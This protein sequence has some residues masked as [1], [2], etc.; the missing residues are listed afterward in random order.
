[1]GCCASTPTTTTLAYEGTTKK[2][3]NC[4]SLPLLRVRAAELFPDL[5]DMVFEMVDKDGVNWNST[6]YTRTLQQNHELTVTIRRLTPF[7]FE[8]PQWERLASA[9][10][11]LMTKNRVCI[12]VGF[13]VSPTHGVTS[14]EALKREERTGLTAHFDKLEP[15]EVEVNPV[16]L[17]KINEDKPQALALITFKDPQLKRAFIRLDRAVNIAEGEPTTALYVRSM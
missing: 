15:K 6:N 17:L 16:P 12:A 7:K 1:M 14:W 4:T 11:R 10:F 9:V 8:D 13:M 2:V 5:H 3:S